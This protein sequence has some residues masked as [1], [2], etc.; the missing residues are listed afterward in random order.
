MFDDRMG[1]R[2]QVHGAVQ[3]VLQLFPPADQ[4]LSIM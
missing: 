1:R 2:D 4:V 3:H